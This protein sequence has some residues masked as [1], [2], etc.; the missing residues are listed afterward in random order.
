MVIGSRMIAPMQRRLA[1]MSAADL[2]IRILP[3]PAAV[4]PLVAML[5]WPMFRDE[6][7]GSR[8]LRELIVA[9]AREAFG[10]PPVLTQGAQA[11]A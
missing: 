3:H 2:P 10:E 5:Q 11:K 9:T 7:P 6:D 8:W 4:P 1:E